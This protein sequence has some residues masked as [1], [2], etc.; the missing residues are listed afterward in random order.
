MFFSRVGCR[1][2]YSQNT[3][4]DSHVSENKGVGL[5]LPVASSENTKVNY[6]KSLR[7][8]RVI[9]GCMELRMIEYS[10]RSISLILKAVDMT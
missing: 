6:L 5:Q 2:N 4:G 7:S 8:F 3:N 10:E 9:V 1:G